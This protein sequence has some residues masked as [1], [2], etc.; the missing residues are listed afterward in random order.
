MLS[1]EVVIHSIMYY[2]AHGIMWNV[3]I[4]SFCDTRLHDVTLRTMVM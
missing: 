4:K 2:L 3:L 1:A